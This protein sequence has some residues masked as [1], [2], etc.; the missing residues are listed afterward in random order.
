M[1]QTMVGSGKL[2]MGAAL[3]G[4]HGGV[5]LLG[6][7]LLWWRDHAAVLALRKPAAPFCPPG[8]PA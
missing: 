4:L 2:S 7:S 8:Q 3:L 6:L 5:L 1:S